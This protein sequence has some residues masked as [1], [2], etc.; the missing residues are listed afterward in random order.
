MRPCAIP[1]WLLLVGC[2]AA[3]PARAEPET[4]TSAP[5]PPF[6]LVRTLQSLQNEAA[7][8]NRTAQAAQQPL[9]RELAGA[10][11]RQDPELWK[12]PRNTR[13]LVAYVLSGGPPGVLERV[14][15]SGALA[16][17]PEGLAAGALAYV[18]GDAA[19][20]RPLLA[21]VDAVALGGLLGGQLAL[22]QAS[23]LAR[24]EPKRALEL[25]DQARLLAPGTLIEEG[26]LRR[27]VMVSAE[28]GDLD[29]LERAL[30]QY[31][32]RFG[33]SVYAAAFRQSFLSGLVR[34]DFGREAE[35][36][37]RLLAILRPLAPPEQREALLLVARDALLAGR[38]EQARLASEAAS[39]IE[40]ADRSAQARA[41][42]YGA[43]AQLGLRR[44][45]GA[46]GA[47]AR[48]DPERLGPEDREIL[49]N[50]RRIAA[51]ITKW[52]AQATRVR[53]SET[54]PPELDSGLRQVASSVERSLAEAQ[55][56]I[57]A[58]PRQRGMAR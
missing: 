49:T 32:R 26:A 11:E 14:N 55:G 16:P 31:E 23:L 28:T 18:S 50:A 35:K 10:L 42:L 33:A 21:P 53:P 4:G 2:L 51:G 39:Q 24:A 1:G 12:E 43:A 17:L 41:G 52:P 40:G 45:T 44:T 54:P 57:E 46:G 7:Q 13:A 34:H 38:F 25:L 37:P 3:G 36:F 48:L 9:L 5:P 30:A 29:R 22:V 56:L 58:K 47:L 20:A 8:G 15:D 27:A 6:Q 19:K